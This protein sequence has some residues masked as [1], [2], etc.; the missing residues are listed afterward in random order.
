MGPHG[1]PEQIEDYINELE[2]VRPQDGP[3]RGV[4]LQTVD[5]MDANTERR[6]A[7]SHHEIEAWAIIRAPTGDWSARRLV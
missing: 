4:L 2:A 7:E 6:I 3:W 1:G 5:H